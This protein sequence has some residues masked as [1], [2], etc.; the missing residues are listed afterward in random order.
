M[1]FFWSRDVLG[2]SNSGVKNIRVMLIIKE[3]KINTCIVNC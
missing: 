1:K 2:I 3:H